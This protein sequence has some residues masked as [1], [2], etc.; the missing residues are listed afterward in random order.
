MVKNPVR[1]K[2]ILIERAKEVAVG[3]KRVFVAASG[4]IDSSL[5]TVILCSAFGPENVVALH[6]NIKSNPK[7]FEDVKR[8]QSLFN[9]KLLFIDLN[10]IYD[11]IINKLEE[12]FNT[13]DLL[14]AKENSTEA[15][16]YGFTNAYAS[17]K[18][19]FIT[20]LAGFISKAIDC[21]NGRIFGTGNGEEDGLLR[22]FDKFGDGAVDNNI[23]N[24]LTKAEVRQMARYMGVP[25][26]IITKVPSADLEAN[27]DIHNDES[28]LTCWAK[29]MGFDVNISY[30]EPDGSKEGNIAWVWKEDI[31]HGITTGENKNINK[32]LLFEKFNYSEEQISTILFVREIEKNTR[33]KI[34]PIPGLERQILIN[35]GLVD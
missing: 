13:V 22:Y 11:D 15:D 10:F 19:R 26:E 6:R 24:G 33:H 9:F 2:E 16:K 28:Q 25:E 27:G 34:N 3:C 30:G 18:S 14:W 29:K 32:E 12:Q 17:L 35:S 31:K 20:P 7:H 23:L 21:G 4:G 8:L 5:V 1:L